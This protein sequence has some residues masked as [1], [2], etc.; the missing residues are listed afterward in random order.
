MLTARPKRCQALGPHPRPLGF[1]FDATERLI[2]DEDTQ[3]LCLGRP[4]AFGTPREDC[5]RVFGHRLDRF[6]AK[7]RPE[8]VFIRAGFDAHREDPVGNLGLETE[9]F[10]TLT[11]IVL[12]LAEAH[13]GGRVISVLESGYHPRRVP[14]CVEVH[15]P[16][17]L[18]H[19]R[20]CRAFEMP[21]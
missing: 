6:D 20:T 16:E 13:A 5:L 19:R 11:R 21:R 2:R 17:M 1:L 7:I 15:L 14:E 10:A 18:K 9:D 3:A 12:E 8:L 4:P